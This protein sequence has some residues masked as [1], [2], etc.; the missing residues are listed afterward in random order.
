MASRV[1]QNLWRETRGKEMGLSGSRKREVRTKMLVSHSE[2]RVL[3]HKGMERLVPQAH[4]RWDT[5]E[6]IYAA[7]K[8]P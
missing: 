8:C 7:P 2:E 1:A 4:M 5:D 3:H 6:R